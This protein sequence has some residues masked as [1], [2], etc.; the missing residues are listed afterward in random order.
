MMVTVVT[1][2]V[3]VVRVV[4]VFSPSSVITTD[5]TGADSVPCC[6]CLITWGSGL[7]TSGSSRA[8]SRQVCHLKFGEALSSCTFIRE[9]NTGTVMPEIFYTY[10]STRLVVS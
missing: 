7:V 1:V 8:T 3:V 6:C 5:S 9:L 10:F 4:V 2:L